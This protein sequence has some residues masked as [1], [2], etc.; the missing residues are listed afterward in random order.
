MLGARGRVSDPGEAPMPHAGRGALW[1]PVV[2]M[3]PKRGRTNRA[4]RND[5]FR[6]WGLFQKRI[7]SKNFTVGRFLFRLTI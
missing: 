2:A 5:E 3:E 6:L 1:P 4:W 7:Q